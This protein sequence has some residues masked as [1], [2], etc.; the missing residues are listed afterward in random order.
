M[1]ALRFKGKLH[2]DSAGM[3][4]TNNAE[5][6]RLLKPYFRKGWEFHTVKAQSPLSVSWPSVKG[7]YPDSCCRRQAVGWRR[8]F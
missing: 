6:N 8:R 7:G 4:I 2:Y 1:I 3:Q 5:A